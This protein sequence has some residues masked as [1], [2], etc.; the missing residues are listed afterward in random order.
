MAG[1]E[2]VRMCV[3]RF[4]KDYRGGYP[5]KQDLLY[6]IS[7]LGAPWVV[8]SDLRRSL[9]GAW[10]VVLRSLGGMLEVVWR[11]FGGVFGPWD[12]LW[13][14]L[15]CYFAVFER[16][17]GCLVAVP[18]WCF[19]CLGVPWAVLGRLFCGPWEVFWVVI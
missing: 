3:D 9:G 10:S 2:F 1:E 13:R 17:L 4:C 15:D 16:C 8:L 7:V 6:R 5:P 14:C 11:S 19:R 12:V 18:G